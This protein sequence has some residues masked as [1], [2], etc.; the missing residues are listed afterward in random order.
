MKLKVLIVDD[1]ALM[2]RYL[3]EIL[4]GALDVELQGARDG[5]EALLRIKEWDPH[6]VTLDINMPKMDGLTCLSHI[7]TDYPRPVVMVSSLTERDALATLEALGMGAVDFVTKPGGT[8]SMNIKQVSAELVAKVRAAGRQ[9]K[10]KRLRQRA[11]TTTSPTSSPSSIQAARREPKPARL[12]SP[13]MD[14]PRLVL[15]GVSTGGPST[16]EHILPLL[17][18]DLAAPVL[19]AQHMPGNFTRVFAERLDSLCKLRVEEVQRRTKLEPGHVYIAKGDADVEVSRLGFGL[20]ATTVP[21]GSDYVW[22][23]SVD[24]MVKTAAEHVDPAAMVGVILTG[25]GNDGAVPLAEL[26]KRGAR[27]IAESEQT[28]I[29]FGMPAELIANGGAE[30]VLPHDEIAQQLIDWVGHG[31]TNGT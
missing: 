8:V 17:P 6:V 20:V 16:L 4:E 5:A 12:V 19:I 7:M 3:G 22:H 23:P 13:R 1:S 9:A 10:I 27:T 26:H 25:M 14:G 11:P 24:R 29:I 28:A 15:I 18:A 31:A 21:E 30:L 2:R